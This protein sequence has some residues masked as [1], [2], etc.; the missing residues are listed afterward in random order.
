MGKIHSNLFSEASIY[1]NFLNKKKRLS[2]FFGTLSDRPAWLYTI[3]V[4]MNYSRL[5]KQVL[6]YLGPLDDAILVEVDVDVFSKPRAVVIPHSLGI[7]KSL[8]NGIG[9]Q[10]LLLNPGVFAADGRQVLEDQLGALSLPRPGLAAD[11]HTLVLPKHRFYLI[12]ENCF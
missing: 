7:T 10:Y 1:C 11:D 9:L 3:I 5:L 4:L 12:E 8:Q 2:I 6:I